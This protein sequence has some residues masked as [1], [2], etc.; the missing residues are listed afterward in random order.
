MNETE[1]DFLMVMRRKKKISQ[2]TLAQALG[3][4][5]TLVSFIENGTREVDKN[6][7][8]QYKKYILEK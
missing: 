5:Q 8:D 1:R 2:R 7:I 4:S 3:I 6:Y